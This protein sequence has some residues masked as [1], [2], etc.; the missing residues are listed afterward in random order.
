VTLSLVRVPALKPR[1]VLAT[2]GMTHDESCDDVLM[3]HD[4][5][6][7]H[8]NQNF[9]RVGVHSSMLTLRAPLLPESGDGCAFHTE[10]AHDPVNASL[11]HPSHSLMSAIWRARGRIPVARIQPSRR[12]PPLFFDPKQDASNAAKK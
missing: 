12:T 3:S 7:K 8:Q 10:R 4:D 5:R 2:D 6:V 1:Q 9:T 11:C